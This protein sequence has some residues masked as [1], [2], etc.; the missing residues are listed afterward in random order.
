MNDLQSCVDCH[1]RYELSDYCRKQKSR[2][3]KVHLIQCTSVSMA[4]V[5]NGRTVPRLLVKC[6]SCND[7]YYL[8]DK[9]QCIKCH[10]HGKTDWTGHTNSNVDVSHFTM[11]QK[12]KQYQKMVSLRKKSMYM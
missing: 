9:N 1:D 5:P 6:A 4:K 2:S 7:G 8:N 12:I 11:H 10:E 3:Q